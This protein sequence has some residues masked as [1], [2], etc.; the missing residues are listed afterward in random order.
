MFRRTSR[1]LLALA[2]LLGP[3]GPAAAQAPARPEPAVPRALPVE[4]D[5][6]SPPALDPKKVIPS[7]R[8]RATPSAVPPHESEIIP[9]GRPVPKEAPS[10]APP[11]E[12]VREGK[13]VPATKPPLPGSTRK[14]KEEPPLEA[15]TRTQADARTLYI[16]LPAPRGLIVDRFGG[17][18]AQNILAYYPAVQFPEGAAMK[19]ADAL[20]LCQT[21]NP[22][23][24]EGPRHRVDPEGRG[25]PRTLPE[26]PMAPAPL[27]QGAQAS[28]A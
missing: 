1:L 18:L 15:S 12:I 9:E 25:H 4:D 20:A 10:I 11:A 27:R 13:P 17:P 19:P 7:A 14:A 16:T 22:R 3:A 23:R 8:A 24:L 6:E 5:T 21:A 28:A 26:S 2:S